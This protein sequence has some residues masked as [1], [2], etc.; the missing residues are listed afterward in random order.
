MF[1]E[2]EKLEEGFEK[3]DVSFLGLCYFQE[4]PGVSNGRRDGWL[5][6]QR[7]SSQGLGLNPGGLG[8]A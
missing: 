3:A 6:S 4:H 8:E 1:R 2:R 7:T 5:D